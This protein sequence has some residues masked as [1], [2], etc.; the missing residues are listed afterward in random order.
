M[1][2]VAIALSMAEHWL[3]MESH[4]EVFL[5]LTD[6]FPVNLIGTMNIRT[7]MDEDFGFMSPLKLAAKRKMNRIFTTHQNNVSL[8]PM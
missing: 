6:E 8:D 2:V 5:Y 4:N 7:K 3:S 1:S